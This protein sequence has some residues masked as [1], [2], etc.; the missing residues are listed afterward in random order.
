MHIRG[1]VSLLNQQN[2]V[3]ILLIFTVSV[4]WGQHLERQDFFSFLFCLELQSVVVK[5]EER[6]TRKTKESV[7]AFSNPMA[8]QGCEVPHRWVV[9]LEMSSIFTCRIAFDTLLQR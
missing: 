5:K 4:F 6:K 2:S 7:L 3:D 8:V 1:S 9:S